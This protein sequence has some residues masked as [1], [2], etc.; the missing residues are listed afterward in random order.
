MRKLYFFVMFLVANT[1]CYSQNIVV[2]SHD[3][4]IRYS[5]RIAM[6][7]D[8]AELSWSASSIKMNFKGTSVKATLKD[9]HGYDYW[10][11]IIDGNV[12]SVIQPD[13]IQKQYTLAS[14]LTDGNHTVELFK[15]TEWPM[16]KMWFY[17]FEL[18]R[19][20]S[21]LQPPPQQKRKIEFF[22]DSITCGYA[23]EDS[24]GQDRG[25]A[26]Y[27]NA[28]LSYASI[29][30]RHFDAELHSTSKSGIGILVSWVPLIMSEMY[31]RLDAT[32]AESKWDFSKYTPNLVVINLFQNDS[33]IVKL[34]DNDQFKARFGTKPPT[35]EQIIKAYKDFVKTIRSKYPKAQI[36][37]ALGSME[38]VKEGTPWSGYVQKA[39]AQIGDKKIYTHFFPYKNT[40]GHPSKKEQQAIAD[41]LIV[42][43]DQ[44]IKW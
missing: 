35:D 42:F 8:A 3:V 5:G 19:N 10:S 23:I 26:P 12:V 40:P 25:T 32:D 18:D 43:I 20:A 1:S 13:S 31:Y 16:G 44:N 37:C 6:T 22:G 21:V 30:A 41:D 11:V 27:E 4:H 33:W 29:T 34:P 28:Y 14:G 9:E 15:R 7:D 2:K 24:T 38:A 36:I 17:G 39:V